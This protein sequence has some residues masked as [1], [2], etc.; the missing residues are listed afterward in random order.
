LFLPTGENDLFQMRSAVIGKRH[1][2]KSASKTLSFATRQQAHFPPTWQVSNQ[3]MFLD[4][5]FGK[6]LL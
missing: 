6:V 4:K 5:T 3:I 2:L 1:K